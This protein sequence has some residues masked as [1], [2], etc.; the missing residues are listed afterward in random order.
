MECQNTN[1]CEEN[2]MAER[3][4]LR[5]ILCEKRECMNEVQREH[6]CN[7]NEL[8]NR[9]NTLHHDYNKLKQ[10]LEKL[11]NEHD[12]LCCEISQIDKKLDAQKESVNILKCIESAKLKDAEGLQ[13]QHSDTLEM[14]Q[15]FLDKICTAQLEQKDI[16]KEMVCV[17]KKL[18]EIITQHTELDKTMCMEQNRKECFIS[19]INELKIKIE[20]L[21]R[22][23][24]VENTKLQTQLSEKS[25]EVDVVKQ[26]I[27]CKE[28]EIKVLKNLVKESE[29]ALKTILDNSRKEK[30]KLEMEACKL[31]KE[32]TTITSNLVAS[33]TKLCETQKEYTT[34]ENHINEQKEV[35]TVL[36]STKEQLLQKFKKIKEAKESTTA[37]M[38]KLRGLRETERKN[39]ETQSA[40]K[41]KEKCQLNELIKNQLEEIKELQRQIFDMKI[42]QCVT[43]D[44][45]ADASPLGS[46]ITKVLRD[47]GNK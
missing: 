25:A 19:S 5:R 44:K 1:C 34:L 39:F 45:T 43:M 9:N 47:K 37:M 6:T 12:Q 18:A 29:A 41:N 10:E 46:C 32:I 20:K 35:I 24:Q 22:L 23:I 17:Q 27:K 14:K 7:F 16:D 28:A 2:L 36:E 13:K 26:K 11:E 8:I 15:L 30:C 38:T 3:D 21:N 4:E 40:F 33:K 42:G 31:N